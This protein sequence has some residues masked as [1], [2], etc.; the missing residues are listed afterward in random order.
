MII[1]V[2]SEG[3]AVDGGAPVSSRKDFAIVDISSIEK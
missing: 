3:E 1:S 2:E